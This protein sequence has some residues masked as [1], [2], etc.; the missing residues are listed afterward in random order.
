MTITAGPAL[1]D[2]ISLDVD[3]LCTAEPDVRQDLPDSVHKMRVATRRLRSVL[4]SY[5][6]V[7]RRTPVG[8][9]TDELR[10]LAGLLGVA[11]DAE[12][13]AERFAKLL[14]ESDAALDQSTAG[15]TGTAAKAKA[16]GNG[17]NRSAAK[18][19]ADGGPARVKKVRVTE[20]PSPR[21]S[22]GAELVAME[23]RIYVGAHQAV[24]E[25]FDGRRYNALTARLHDLIENPPLRN[26]ASGKPA[27]DVFEA[28]LK[29]DFHE[30]RHLVRVEPTLSEE[31]R[32]EHLHDIRKAA[33]RLRYSAEAAADILGDPATTLSRNAK[34]LQG[35][36]GDHR[37]AVEALETLRAH[38]PDTPEPG[39]QRMCDAEES[40]AAK[41]LEEYPA[42]IEFL[43]RHPLQAAV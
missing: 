25:A 38:A 17:K 35:V 19:G 42:A 32:V 31:D 16:A 14:D 23:R 10:W 28:V 6:R 37:D 26:K 34:R 13:R 24:L 11:R 30:L 18:S 29:H 4:K 33:K 2:A 39:Y 9:I 3:R 21:T 1:V 43:S 27:T 7:V 36:L 8:E 40:A 22:F 12:V 5:R 15:T 41:A 20:P